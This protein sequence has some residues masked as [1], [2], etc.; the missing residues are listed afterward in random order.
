[1]RIFIIRLILKFFSL[2]SLSFAHGTGTILGKLLYKLPNSLKDT[3]SANI[4]YCFPELSHTQKQKLIH[5]NLIETAKNV[6]EAGPLWF[7]PMEK[8]TPY[9]SEGHGYDDLKIALGRGKGA[10]I[11]APHL[12]AWEIVGLHCATLYPMTSLYR[13]PKLKALN[14]VVKKGREKS[15][16]QLVPTDNRGIRALFTALRRNELI[17]IL[18]DQDPGKNNGIFSP[19]FGHQANTMTLVSKLAIKTQAPVFYCFAER[20][21]HGQGYKMHYYKAEFAINDAPLNQSVALMNKEVEKL[22]LQKPSQYQWSYKRFKT[23]PDNEPA[24]Y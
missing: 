17:G 7:W 14:N 15:T 22:I 5:A 4:N 6:T 3:V 1:M 24:M 8:L 23:R 18:P 21:R 10:I 19:F 16:A 11:V 20:R 13:P 9:I 2:G 12:G